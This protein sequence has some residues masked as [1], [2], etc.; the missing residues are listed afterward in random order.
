MEPGIILSYTNSRHPVR[1]CLDTCGFSQ[2]EIAWELG[3]WGEEALS[4]LIFISEE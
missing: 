4:S 1:P 3:R 2:E